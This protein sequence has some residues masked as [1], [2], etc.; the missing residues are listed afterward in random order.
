MRPLIDEDMRREADRHGDQED[1][2]LPPI[3]QTRITDESNCPFIQSKPTRQMLGERSF[4]EHVEEDEEQDT[5]RQRLQEESRNR[6]TDRAIW[7]QEEKIFKVRRHTAKYKAAQ[8][9]VLGSGRFK[10]SCEYRVRKC[11]RHDLTPSLEWILGDLF[12]LS[13]E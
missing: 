11:K 13:N 2:P 10:R 1:Q 5:E 6:M 7:F 8:A 4:D 9:K 3:A 12:H